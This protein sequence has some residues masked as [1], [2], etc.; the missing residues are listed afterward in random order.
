[1]EVCWLTRGDWHT[2]PPSL[3]QPHPIGPYRS[4]TW[5]LYC[6][7]TI[8]LRDM[9]T[10]PS[11]WRKKKCNNFGFQLWTGTHNCINHSDPF[12]WLIVWVWRLLNQCVILAL[13]CYHTRTKQVIRVVVHD[14]TSLFYKPQLD[15]KT[16]ITFTYLSIVITREHIQ[17]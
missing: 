14:Y 6:D 10:E 5:Y 16:T 17:C 9:L 1:M 3:N 7:V 4:N 11:G 12:R 13:L 15:K 8:P 2:C